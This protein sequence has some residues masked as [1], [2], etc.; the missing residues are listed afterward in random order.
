MEH[1]RTLSNCSPRDAV[2]ILVSDSFAR[3]FA[4]AIPVVLTSSEFD[5]SEV[6]WH[7]VLRFEFDSRGLNVPGPA[8]NLLPETVK[9]VWDQTWTHIEDDFATSN[10]RI[11]LVQPSATTTGEATFRREGDDLVFSFVGHTKVSVPLI[12]GPWPSSSTHNW[13]RQCSTIRSRFYLDTSSHSASDGETR[14]LDD[15]GPSGATQVARDGFNVPGRPWSRSRKYR[16]PRFPD[17]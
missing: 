6:P 3:D 13:F 10:L 8:R 16:A 17:L 12:G 14:R 4:D 15:R 11:D 1:T 9:M 5:E 2:K 7:Q